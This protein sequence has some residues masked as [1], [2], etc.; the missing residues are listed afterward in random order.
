MP[1]IQKFCT[2]LRQLEICDNF[3]QFSS[4]REDNQPRI[5]QPR[6]E[7]SFLWQQSHIEYLIGSRYTRWY[8]DWKGNHFLFFFI[9]SCF[10]FS[11][12]FLSLKTLKT[13]LLSF[14]MYV[15]SHFIIKDFFS[16]WPPCYLC[17]WPSPRLQIN[18]ISLKMKCPQ[19][20]I[21]AANG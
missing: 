14:T 15:P 10:L 7:L 2:V 3:L 16:L 9:L 21:F 6:W 13:F 19:W 20:F 18:K 8:W 12:F 1:S 5:T 17:P 4:V 11:V